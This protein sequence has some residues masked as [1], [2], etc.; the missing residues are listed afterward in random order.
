ME[1]KSRLIGAD[2]VIPSDGYCGRGTAQLSYRCPHLTIS[3]QTLEA[4]FVS[5]RLLA[6]QP[7]P[8]PHHLSLSLPSPSSKV[9][10]RNVLCAKMAI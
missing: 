1:N 7:P 8:P 5:S 4:T 2:S 6:C 9:I 3:H 10:A